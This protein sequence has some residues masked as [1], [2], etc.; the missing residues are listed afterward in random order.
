MP[1]P[2]SPSASRSRIRI[3]SRAVFSPDGK[4]ILTVTQ[5]ET[6]RL[7]DTATRKPR[8]SPLQH[9][10]NF[11]HAEFSPDGRWVLTEDMKARV[12]DVATC[13]P[14]V[15]VQGI[16][17][18][19]GATFSPD[20]KTILTSVGFAGGRTRVQLWD[21]YTGRPVGNL[22]ENPAE[23]VA[24]SYSPDGKTI[25]T[26][27][28]DGTARLWD[29]SKETFGG[30]ALDQL[31]S[32]SRIKSEEG[33]IILVGEVGRTGRKFRSVRWQPVGG[34]VPF[35]K[36][37]VLMFNALVHR[38]QDFDSRP[39]DLLAI[40]PR[41][42][43]G[44]FIAL[45]GNHLSMNTLRNPGST[46]F[47]QGTPFGLDAFDG[48]YTTAEAIKTNSSGMPMGIGGGP[49]P[50]LAVAFSP[51]ERTALVASSNNAAELLDMVT[52]KLLGTRFQHRDAVYAVAYHPDGRT[53]LTGSKD[54]SAQL[55]DTA[56][57][58]PIGRPLQHEA[59]VNAVA[60]SPDGKVILT[61]SEDQTAR[62]WDAATGRPLA[63][64]LENGTSV[65]ALAYTPDG[66]M[67][68]T[69]GADWTARFWDAV[70]GYAIGSPLRLRNPICEVAFSSDGTQVLTRSVSEDWLWAIP[71]PLGADV[72]TLMDWVR[73][74]TRLKL[75]EPGGFQN[76][77][78]EE[79]Q[80]YRQRLS[81]AKTA[82]SLEVGPDHSP[83]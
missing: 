11:R 79:R 67:I 52:G 8:G 58:Q 3:L 49:T 38:P 46:T 10:E 7:W 12:W 48:T 35:R 9:G 62:L 75:E 16:P 47:P 23:L 1:R 34:Q 42:S 22:L 36:S 83:R 63:K 68:V 29:A 73:Y 39:Y 55:W 40:S 80:R 37:S 59:S 18:G 17:A 61:G 30:S 81:D 54:K 66:K 15:P 19:A 64:P 53:V 2:A 6:V 50:I 43:C 45:R 74:S 13:Q 72:E 4:T 57:G 51:D 21:S 78:Q 28:R 77:E 71:A 76:L 82:G 27:S 20:G 24:W 69:G 56:T 60:F 33:K 14:R 41:G 25:L 31:G 44:L 65:L 26:A 32:V 5:D 70:T